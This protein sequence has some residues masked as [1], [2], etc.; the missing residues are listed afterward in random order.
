MSAVATV[1]KVGSYQGDVSRSSRSANVKAW[2]A[3][4]AA[5][6][7]GP[8]KGAYRAAREEKRTKLQISKGLTVHPVEICLK[9]LPFT[10]TLAERKLY[11]LTGLTDN[12]IL[13]TRCYEKGYIN[14]NM[15]HYKPSFAISHKKLC[16]LFVFSSQGDELYFLLY[17]NFHISTPF[18]EP[19]ICSLPAKL[20]EQAGRCENEPCHVYFLTLGWIESTR[21]GSNTCLFWIKILFCAQTIL[22]G[23][24]EPAKRTIRL[25]W[26]FNGFQYTRKAQ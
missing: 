12:L 7:K 11:L 1:W 19:A 26:I 10:T 18:S 23:A 5:A 21:P 15:V 20:T 8:G 16:N 13:I 4:R 17:I 22:P 3:D 25:F 24:I 9:C 14:C 2:L 6:V